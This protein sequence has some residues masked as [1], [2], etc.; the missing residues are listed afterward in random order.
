[1]SYPGGS[2]YY[3]AE[4][5]GGY[6][7]YSQWV[8]E[9]ESGS[10]LSSRHL[11]MAVVLLGL[12]SYL[13]SFG[14]MLGVS[15]IDWDVRFAVLAGLLA[16]FGLL[17]RQTPV[18]KVFAALAAI[19]FLD[20]LS[21]VIVVPDGV[22]AGW[23]LWVLVVLNGLQAGAAIFALLNQPSATEEQQ[24]WYAAYAEQY[25]QAA[26]QYYGQYAPQ[27][28]PE[29]GYESATASAQQVAHVQAPEP[30]RAAAPQ[31]AGYAEFVGNTAGA[32]PAA[33]TAGTHPGHPSTGLPNV[34][35]NQAPLGAPATQQTVVSGYEYRTSS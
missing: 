33:H 11:A 4:Q 2:S 7:D 34:G 8:A 12:G 16:A 3:P 27:A 15:G 35:H 20:A 26:A 13:V 9:P 32:P 17:P 23:A 31:E 14:P 5:S 24:A 1:M 10:K 29:A 25:A 18:P 6:G 28:E 22:E 19:G 30:R 21:R